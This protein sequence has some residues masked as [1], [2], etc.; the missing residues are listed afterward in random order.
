[1]KKY[2]VFVILVSLVALLGFAFVSTYF[3][4]VDSLIRPPQAEGENYS[5]QL[6]FKEAVGDDVLLKQPVSGSYRSAYTFIDL[7]GDKDDEVIVFYSKRDELGI[8]RMNVLDKAGGEWVSIADFQSVHNDIQEID[9]ADLNGDGT[10]EIIVGWTVFGES[11]SKLMTVYRIGRENADIIIEPVYAGYYSTFKISDIDCDGNND[12]LSM[13]Y[14][15]AGNTAE[16]TAA[17]LS[18]G[19]NGISERGSFVLDNSISSV[20]AVNFDFSESEN[21]K[22]V[23]VD[24]YKVDGG[25]TTDCF[26]WK[27]QKNDFERYYAA[28]TT[29]GAVSSRISSVLCSDINSDGIIEVPTERFLPNISD[30]D[31]SSP[32]V[33]RNGY[34]GQS[35]INWVTV[36]ESSVDT[37]ES[38]IIMS[39]YGYSFKFSEKWLGKV[40]V[41]NDPQKGVLTF[42]SVDI[43]NG[44]PVRDRKLFS[45]MTLTDIDL[46]TIGEI[47]FSYSQITQL[48]GKYYYS[49][50]FDAG[51]EYGITKKEIKQRIIA[52]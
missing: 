14:A 5:I 11:Y 37:V 46:E 16:Y 44:V 39:Q 12:I 15:T 28:G 50:I 32:N 1:M 2:A 3:R 45:I 43:V 52:G 18:Y 48:K 9:F 41:I 35:L 49:R 21:I 42:W 24:A 4:P 6:A 33:M 25:M 30:T 22:R 10:K 17:L 31:N 20:A 29:V 26:F 47:S 36:S 19:K 13:K 51:V 38:H 8:V 7:T 40:S 34:L 27:T 23:Y